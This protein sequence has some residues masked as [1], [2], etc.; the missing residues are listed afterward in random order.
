MH[1]IN[2]TPSPILQNKTHFELLHKTL[3]TYSHLRVFGCLAYASTIASS[4]LKF[5]P[6]P[7]TTYPLPILHNPPIPP[8]LFHESPPPINLRRSSRPSKTPSYLADY[9]YS[10]QITSNQPQSH[11]SPYHLSHVLSYSSL[12]PTHQVFFIG[13]TIQFKPQTYSTAIKHQCSKDAMDSEI[14]ALFQANN[15]WE[16]TSL[17]PNQKAIGCKIR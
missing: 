17:P 15:T 7:F 5:A 13:I 1:L 9:H 2:R 11:T 6:F 8:H 12:S 3:P 10:L 4:H 16:L 14:Q